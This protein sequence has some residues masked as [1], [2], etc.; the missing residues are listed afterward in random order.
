M[1][2]VSCACVMRDGERSKSI[3]D[4]VLDISVFKGGE[5]NVKLSK[6]VIEFLRQRGVDESS[7][8]FVAN[9][10][11]SDDLM[12][13]VLAVDA[14]RRVNP[15]VRLSAAIPYFP[16]ARQDRVC[17]PGEAHSLAAVAAIINSLNFDEVELLD[18]HSSVTPA[19]IKNST[20][21]PMWPLVV[22]AA[23]EFT[24]ICHGPVVLMAPDQGAYKRVLD[25]YKDIHERTGAELDG[26]VHASKTRDPETMA[27]TSV[28]VFGDVAGKN[29]LI[30]DDICD[31]GRTFIEL[32]ARLRELGAAKVGLYV[33]H[34]IFSYGVK[35]VHDAFDYIA[36]TDSFHPGGIDVLT[37]SA[38]EQVSWFKL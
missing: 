16:Y 7:A 33:T 38:A 15:R 1:I 22:R 3:I 17:Q 28:D 34:G 27:I 10:Q 31:G 29:I 30:V 21:E 18:P 20:Q 24:A 36:S 13:L 5:V 11:G 2:R 4:E 35:I 8:H 19:L 26:F 9:I 14:I 6:Q 25:I 37:D 23:R 32:S 12:A